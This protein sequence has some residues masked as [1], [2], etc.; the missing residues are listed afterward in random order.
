LTDE[1]KTLKNEPTYKI[2]EMKKTTCDH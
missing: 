2:V 1:N